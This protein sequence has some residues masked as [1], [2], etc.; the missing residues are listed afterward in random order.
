MNRQ[1]LLVRINTFLGRFTQEVKQ[2]N[3]ASQYDIN[4]HAENVLIP[5]LREIFDYKGL[6]NAN[7]LT[8]NARAID[9]VDYE[10]RVSIQVTSTA[11]AQKITETL[12]KFFQSQQQRA[13]DRLV[14]YVIT[15]RQDTYR[16]DFKKSI[17][18]DFDFDTQRDIIDNAGLFEIISK[19]ILNT[20]KLSRIEKLLSDEFSE[21]KIQEREVKGTVEVKALQGRDTIYP[22]LISVL[23]P[24]NLHIADLDFDF[25]EHKALLRDYFKDTK[26][27]WRI[28]H[29]DG[30]HIVNH[31]FGTLDKNFSHD[32][33]LRKGKILTF[34]DLNETN[35]TFRK[36][37][38]LGTITSITL[39]EYENGNEDRLNDLKD[40]LNS[41]LR[42][43][44]AKR[45]IEWIRDE[46]KYRFQIGRALNGRKVS[47]KN[48][49]GRGVVFEVLSKE[50]QKNIKDELGRDRVLKGKHIVCFRHLAFVLNFF[51][52]D[53]R[54]YASIKPDW[55]FTSAMD[56]KRRSRYAEHY[57]TGI[58]ALE[59]NDTIYDQFEFLAD[60]LSSL[61]V[62]DMFSS[63]KIK[64]AKLPEEF[65]VSPSIPDSVW[66]QSEPKSKNT[67][68]QYE[69]FGQ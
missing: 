40:L 1:E 15:D 62:G 26:Q 66:S 34:R 67:I 63:M 32:F 55:S 58:K 49:A 64:L 10:S 50:N 20:S 43:D 36:I 31:F 2:F 35:E 41:T 56:G 60:Y 45:E 52:F 23:P 4:I 69:L 37:I 19:Q 8:K 48:K 16:K 9:L 30:K 46:G 29:I 25:D 28:K 39:P 61:S 14:F 65:S 53:D 68:E 57:M 21:L 27:F 13:F 24:L 7:A 33:I 42:H 11:D 18:G 59:W 44:F 47:Y 54:W 12:Q 51:L 22:N 38:D 5:L 6:L 17:Q 3:E